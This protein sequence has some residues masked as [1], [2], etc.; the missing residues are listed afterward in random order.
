MSLAEMEMDLDSVLHDEENQK[1][2]K[3]TNIILIYKCIYVES[4][5]TY[6]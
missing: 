2:K 3:K 5:W 1:E 4:R 6:L